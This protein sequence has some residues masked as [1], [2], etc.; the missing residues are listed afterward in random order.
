MYIYNAEE[1]FINKVE[2]YPIRKVISL[3][4]PVSYI[5]CLY[6]CLIIS[7]TFACI[8]NA[9]HYFLKCIKK[10]YLY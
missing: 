7:V 2:Y 3:I 5:C 10:K 8:L 4:N 1:L 6:K 9:L